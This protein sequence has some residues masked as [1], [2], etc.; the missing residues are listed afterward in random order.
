[1]LK[2]DIPG[3]KKLEIE[4]LVLD[5][6]GTTACDGMVS[7]E[8]KDKINQVSD[9]LK[10]HV[11]TADTFGT[12]SKELEG[13]NCELVILD[14]TDQAEQKAQFLEELNPLRTIAVGNGRND[15]RMLN[16][17]AIGIS[18]MNPE[19]TSVHALTNSDI[20]CRNFPEVMELLENP[21]RL[22]ATLRT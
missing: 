2:L 22:K 8:I 6:N 1:M 14:E 9:F 10:V 4:H 20:V 15:V 13:L 21:R 7:E 17:A 12:A 18:V 11:L 5:L 3:F 19:G 16:F